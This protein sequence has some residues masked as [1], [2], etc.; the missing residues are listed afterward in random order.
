MEGQFEAQIAALKAK[1]QVSATEQ[2]ELKQKVEAQKAEAAE[3][4]TRL[5]DRHRKAMVELG[6]KHKVVIEKKDSDAHKASVA[7]AR[8]GAVFVQEL[9]ATGSV[10]WV[11][12]EVCA[13]G[14]TTDLGALH[15]VVLVAGVHVGR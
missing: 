13:S 6:R 1:L 10:S 15:P 11:W 3:K 12:C 2:Q 14:K 4:M 8:T 5:K 9:A 7:G